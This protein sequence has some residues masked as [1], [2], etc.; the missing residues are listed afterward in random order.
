MS[1]LDLGTHESL[2]S[3][4]QPPSPVEEDL[5]KASAWDE[6][7]TSTL[8]SS[9]WKGKGKQRDEDEN[10]EDE[11]DEDDDVTVNGG[12]SRRTSNEYPPVGEEDIESRK[13]EQNLKRWEI[14]EKQRRKRARESRTSTSSKSD[15]PSSSSSFSVSDVSR[16]ASQLWN[17]RARERPKDRMDRAHPHQVL[18]DVDE[19][20]PMDETGP[21][22]A[23]S[24]AGTPR[25]SLLPD[26]PSPFPHTN[27]FENPQEE[28]KIPGSIMTAASSDSLPNTTANSVPNGAT[29][30]PILQV[31]GSSYTN[32]PPPQPLDLPTSASSLPQD[33]WR[34]Q[35]VDTEEEDGGKRWWTDWLCGCR[36]HGDNQA[37]RTNPME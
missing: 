12:N 19:S 32:H 30:R 7:D 28:E 33:G 27:P 25:T 3:G 11:D 21:P 6:E 31:R 1:S 10:E 20:V 13:V 34:S 5:A 15:S 24:P 17:T 8:V 29:E 36:E 2:S 22:S 4:S 16:R 26:T 18:E 23:S 37:G 35:Q 14:L 9:K